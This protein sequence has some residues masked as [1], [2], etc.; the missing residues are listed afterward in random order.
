[1]T[2]LG[3]TAV[4]N[5]EIYQHVTEFY[6]KVSSGKLIY[7]CGV[8]AA[9]VS[10]KYNASFGT[11]G[12]D[13]AYLASD[14]FKNLIRAT[15]K[16]NYN[17][18]VKIIGTG[19]AIPTALNTSGSV[20]IPADVVNSVTT[21]QTTHDA[22]A[23]EGYPF[24]GVIDGYN[25]STK[26]TP[27][28][29]YDMSA[30]GCGAIQLCI[31][32]SSG[33]GISSVGAYLGK[34][35]SISI[36]HSV[37]DKSDGPELAIQAAYFTNSLRVDVGTAIPTTAGL[38]FYVGGASI[39]YNSIVYE[40]GESFVYDST[41]TAIS[42]SGYVYYTDSAT[43]ITK[44]DYTLQGNKDSVIGFAALGT[45]QY[46]FLRTWPGLSGYYYNDGATCEDSTLALSSVEYQRV[47]NHFVDAE[48]YFGNTEI[49][50]NMIINSST[51]QVD[52]GYLKTLNQTF[53][54][55]YIKPLK[56]SP[57]GTGDISDGKIVYAPNP[58]NPK[59][60]KF[61]MQVTLSE[62]LEAIEGS[63]TAVSSITI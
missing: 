50:K 35:A 43:D 61:T 62:I 51:G 38:Y 13:G 49:G 6:D 18:K 25:M 52:A 54:N 2:A 60:L 23:K 8:K 53:Y 9:G 63:I 44:I 21:L 40:P 27:E 56:P 58:D 16:L 3:I 24:V 12:G 34:L 36:G 41:H 5:P 55:L 59:R 10:G 37:S 4:N 15:A 19:Y 29:L 42:G 22:M 47:M 32:G 17:Y 57:E 39:T 11:S 28:N 20:F 30:A 7:I 1:M 48:T 26:A 33:N 45:S 14:T 46:L 31:T